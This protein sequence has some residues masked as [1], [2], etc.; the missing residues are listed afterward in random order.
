MLIS[1]HTSWVIKSYNTEYNMERRSL[2]ETPGR[3]ADLLKTCVWTKRIWSEWLNLLSELTFNFD[4]KT[5]PNRRQLNFFYQISTCMA[6]KHPF[7][8]SSLI[9]C[10]VNRNKKNE[11]LTLGHL[12]LRDVN[13]RSR[14]AADVLNTQGNLEQC[15]Y[16]A[17]YPPTRE[18]FQLTWLILVLSRNSSIIYFRVT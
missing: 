16:R 4:F 14:S 1:V 11:Q 12:I 18:L 3:S 17:E 8:S 2:L 15:L 5:C 13:N 9:T 6:H 7:H 10:M